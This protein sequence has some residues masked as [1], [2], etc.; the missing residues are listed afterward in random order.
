MYASIRDRSVW[1]R[2]VAHLKK[3]PGMRT[4][5]EKV[6]AFSMDFS[7][8]SPYEALVETFIYQQI[9]GKAADSI[10]KKFKSL[11]NG[12]IPTPKQFLA[13]S[14]KKI[15]NAGVSPQKYSYIKDLCTRV[16]GRELDLEGL[17]ELPDEEVIAILDE[18]KGI[19]RWT[20]EMF[21]MFHLYR[22]D[23]FALD[24]LGL[25]NAVIRAYRIRNPS[26]ERLAMISGRWKPYRSIAS[27][28]LWRYNDTVTIK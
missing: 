4:V 27:L 14:Q 20:A 8:E 19:G 2:G 28:Y 26:K 11:Y 15:A 13:T 6:G 17:K 18:I 21:L 25:R 3:D 5:I 1:R 10:L 22:V 23:I 16:A 24:D 12:R 9:S 7:S